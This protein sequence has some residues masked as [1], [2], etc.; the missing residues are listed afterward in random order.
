MARLYAPQ[1]SLALVVHSL[2]QVPT[3]HPIDTHPEVPTIRQIKIVT[4]ENFPLQHTALQS[5]SNSSGLL[6]RETSTSWSTESLWSPFLRKIPLLMN[7]VFRTWNQLSRTK[8]QTCN[9]SSNRGL[10]WQQSNHS[11]NVKAAHW[12]EDAS[13]EASTSTRSAA[14]KRAQQK[15]KQQKEL[16]LREPQ[17]NQ[18]QG[19][20]QGDWQ[21]LS[22][23]EVLAA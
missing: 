18:S 4:K 20:V 5:S 7:E 21:G 12:E 23:A 16:Y 3:S 8:I 9:S 19:Q 15:Q 14:W 17:Q 1:R 10:R 11:T 22:A 13:F 2:L 6:A